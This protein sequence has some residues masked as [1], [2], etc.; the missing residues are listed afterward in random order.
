M[1][2]PREKRA[3]IVILRTRMIAVKSSCDGRRGADAPAIKAARRRRVGSI[4]VINRAEFVNSFTVEEKRQQQDLLRSLLISIENCI[5]IASCEYQSIT[6]LHFCLA[7][8]GHMKSVEKFLFVIF[9][10]KN[11]KKQEK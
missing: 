11:W 3:Q 4:C 10:N 9:R 7:F 1:Y 6:Y 2:V 8:I 5:V